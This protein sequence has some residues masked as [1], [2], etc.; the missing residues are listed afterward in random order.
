M[1]MQLKLIDRV[2]ERVKEVPS[3]K[4]VRIGNGAYDDFSVP[5]LKDGVSD[6]HALIIREDC[7]DFID[8]HQGPILINGGYDGITPLNERDEITI[9]PNNHLSAIKLTASYLGG[10]EM[11]KRYSKKSKQSRQEVRSAMKRAFLNLVKP[12]CEEEQK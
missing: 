8:A 5:Q 7:G 10:E 11:R 4:I 1:N 2:N 6:S 9:V 12:F 3:K